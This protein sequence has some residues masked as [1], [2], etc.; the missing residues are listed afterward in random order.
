MKAQIDAPVA[1][2]VLDLDE[3]GLLDRTL[4]VL[5]SELGRDMVQESEPDQPVKDH[6]D[7]PVVFTEPRHFGMHRHFTDAASVLMFARRRKSGR[8]APSRIR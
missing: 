6:V 4:I 5:A 2:L 8:A 3:R 7:V 1:Q